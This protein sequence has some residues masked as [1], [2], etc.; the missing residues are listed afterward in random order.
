[1]QVVQQRRKVK[2]ADPLGRDT[3]KLHDSYIEDK[4]HLLEFLKEISTGE[5]HDGAT[6]IDATNDDELKQVV[7]Y[8]VRL[9]SFPFV[10]ENFRLFQK[11]LTRMR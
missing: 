8:N 1:M 6:V 4:D 7:G 11:I 3:I 2:I 5:H 9:H 10:S